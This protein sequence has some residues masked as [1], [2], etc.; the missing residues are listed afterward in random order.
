MVLVYNLNMKKI[1]EIVV[2]EGQNDI[3]KVKSCVQADVLKTNG[4]HLSQ[5]FIEQLK[6]LNQQRGVIV[7]TDDDYPG[8]W[9][10]SQIQEALG[11]CKHA[12]IDKKVSR[13]EKKVGI[14][15][16]QCQDILKALESVSTYCNQTES[17]SF[18]EYLEADLLFNIEKRKQLIQKLG[19]PPMN[20]KRFF[21]VLNLMGLSRKDLEL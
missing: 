15:H 6:R 16:A 5:H 12:Y 13:T 18:Q 20:N 21:K 17:L 9:I 11:T 8:R 1:Q 3:N 14:E 19:L 10:R 4:T 2:V 7:M